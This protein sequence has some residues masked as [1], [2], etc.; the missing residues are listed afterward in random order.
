[1][2]RRNMLIVRYLMHAGA[3]ACLFWA[4]ATAGPI[5]VTS[6]TVQA[7]GLLFTMQTGKMKLKACTDNIVRVTYTPADSFSTRPSLMV[8]DT[9]A[10]PLAWSVDS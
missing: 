3:L 9:F 1:M 10:T 8:A 6:F 5:P 7:D 4:L 2:R